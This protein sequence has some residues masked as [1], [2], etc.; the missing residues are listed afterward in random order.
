MEETIYLVSQAINDQLPGSNIV[1]CFS[2]GNET[3]EKVFD[4][5]NNIRIKRINGRI[6]RRLKRLSNNFNQVVAGDMHKSARGDA[7][8]VALSIATSGLMLKTLIG[9]IRTKKAR[10]IIINAYSLNALFV[11]AL[12]K[13]VFVNKPISI[14]FTN[15]FTYKKSGIFHMDQLI[16]WSLRSCAKIIS[17]SP[18]SAAATVAEFGVPIEKIDICKNWISNTDLPRIATDILPRD[19]ISFLFVG[20]IVPEKG[21]EAI[22]ALSEYIE[23]NNLPAEIVIAGDS[24]HPVKKK[25]LRLAQKNSKT[26]YLGR[27]S[28]SE[29]WNI[30]SSSD[31]LL[32]PVTWEEGFGRVIIESYASGTPVIGTPKGALPD[33]IGSFSVG[34]ISYQTSPKYLYEAGAILKHKINQIGKHKFAAESRKTIKDKYSSDNF[35]TY[36]R[37]YLSL[38]QN[39]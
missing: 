33:V 1:I 19:S 39:D 36:R 3:T 31:V 5:Q 21:I 24:N 28:R 17:V 26:K 22:L 29:L 9:V 2:N 11:A 7:S 10:K 37:I 18:T 35:N 4:K 8:M 23:S 6:Y 38:L 20:R 25:M 16:K 14:I 15:Q 13:K 27:V 32:M 30:Y 34:N 12:A